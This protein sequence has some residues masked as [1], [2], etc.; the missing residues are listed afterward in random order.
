MPILNYAKILKITSVMR[1]LNFPK[2][3]AIFLNSV[4]Y[5]RYLC[6][7]ILLLFGVSAAA[8]DYFSRITAASNGRLTRFDHSPITIYVGSIP[9]SGELK[10]EYQNILSESCY[11]KKLLRGR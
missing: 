11:G 7:V 2:L 5:S 6:F 9:V 1:M 8:D 4:F 3:F 10:T